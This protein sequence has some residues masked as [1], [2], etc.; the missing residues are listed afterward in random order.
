MSHTIACFKEE[1]SAKIPALTLLT[2]LGY[3][4][5]PCLKE[6]QQIASVLTA[7]DKEIEILETKLSHFK[8][9]KKALMQ[10]LLTGKRRVKVEK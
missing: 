2:N 5:L 4:I 6:Q 7:V 9:E 8:Q 10:Q 1:Q 3:V